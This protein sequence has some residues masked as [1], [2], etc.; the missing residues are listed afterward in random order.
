MIFVDI[1]QFIKDNKDDINEND[2]KKF[3]DICEEYTTYDDI[4][5][6]IN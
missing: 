2:L 3:R 1:V 6:Y 5:N 4:E